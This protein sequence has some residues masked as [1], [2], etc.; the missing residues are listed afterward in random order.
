M[1]PSL[2]SG[3]VILEKHN[4][5]LWGWKLILLPFYF[6]WR[7]LFRH[8]QL[9]GLRAWKKNF[10]LLLSHHIDPDLVT[11]L[12]KDQ[13]RWFPSI[14]QSGK[15]IRRKRRITMNNL[16]SSM[17]HLQQQNRDQ[18]CRLTLQS[19]GELVEMNQLMPSSLRT[20]ELQSGK[21]GDRKEIKTKMST[22]FYF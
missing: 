22:L 1:K 8:A 20:Q 4:Q 2:R 7:V 17:T 18:T 12:G 11:S 9:P 3:Q 5:P 10:L 21:T 14:F 13:R 19:A 16:H 15:K 6:P